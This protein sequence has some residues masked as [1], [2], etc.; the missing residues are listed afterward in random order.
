LEEIIYQVIFFIIL[1]VLPTSISIAYFIGGKSKSIP[2]RIIKS[3]HGII[4]VIAYLF[5]E[6]ASQ[7]TRTSDPEPWDTAFH[8]IIA[9]AIISAIS[10]FF[11]YVKWKWQNFICLIEGPIAFLI[12][13]TGSAL[14]IWHGV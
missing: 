5:S 13:F 4:L 2:T 3:S 9:I 12:W 1:I 8:I 11:G 14:N 10:S 7:Y 6:Y